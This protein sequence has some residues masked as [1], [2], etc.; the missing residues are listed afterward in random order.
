MTRLKLVLPNLQAFGV[1]RAI[2]GTIIAA[3]ILTAVI[4]LAGCANQPAVNSE[5]STSAIRAAEEV[6][7]G[8]LANAS[9]YLQLAK[10]ELENSKE[11]EKAG[12]REEA[13]S[14]LTRAQA[15][16]ELAVAV[17]RGD[18]DTAAANDAIARVQQLR[19]DNQLSTDG[20]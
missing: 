10:E 20:K 19:K 4:L 15:D 18:A 2:V 9:L 1:A 17:S 3:A 11:L 14:M 7:A 6:G 13:E 5:G 12:K 8:H 16:A